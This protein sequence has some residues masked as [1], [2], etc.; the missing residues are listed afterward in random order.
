M[1][2]HFKNI[3]KSILLVQFVLRDR[4]TS[5]MQKRISILVLLAFPLGLIGAIV[6]SYY[7][8]L[9]GDATYGEITSGLGD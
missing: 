1:R 9:S 4:I 2:Y 5:G 8:R 7:L 6:E 3:R